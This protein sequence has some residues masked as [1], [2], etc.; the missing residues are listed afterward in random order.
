MT[1]FL[2]IKEK[3]KCSSLG[4][5][6]VACQLIVFVNSTYQNHFINDAT[7]EGLTWY[8][9][10]FF[11][12]FLENRAKILIILSWTCSCVFSLPMI[13]IHKQS[14]LNGGAQCLIHVLTAKWHW[15]VMFIL[16]FCFKS[17]KKTV[18]EVVFKDTHRCI[19]VSAL[20]IL[21]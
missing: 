8:N 2:Y 15:Q 14:Y 10:N 9:N 16:S 4:C 20:N 21:L 12:Y 11:V 6:A 17:T 13:F 19:F 1:I 3:A 18:L 7:P 5:F